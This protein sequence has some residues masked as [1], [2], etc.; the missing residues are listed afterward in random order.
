MYYLGIDLGGMSIKAG[1]C[2]DNGKILFSD[3][4][5]TV[6]DEDGDRILNDM[7]KL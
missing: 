2:D 6:R 5:V 7:A 3:T 4:C 1:I